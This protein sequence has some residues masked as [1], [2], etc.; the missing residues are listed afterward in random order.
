MEPQ[1][2]SARNYGTS[3]VLENDMGLFTVF[4]LHFNHSLGVYQIINYQIETSRKIKVRT[5]LPR[6]KRRPEQ[7]ENS[8][9]C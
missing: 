3:S 5:N 4:H 9:F 7:N 6:E 8:I 2:Y 1:S